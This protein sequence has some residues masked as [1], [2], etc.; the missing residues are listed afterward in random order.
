MTGSG[1]SAS[2][3]LIQLIN[4]ADQDKAP[5]RRTLDAIIGFK[6]DGFIANG[7]LRPSRRVTG[8]AAN[9]DT[10]IGRDAVIL[11]VGDDSDPYTHEPIVDVEAFF[12]AA[13]LQ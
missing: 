3:K 9:T 7:A 1:S 4:L 10:R 2:T 13:L 5:S 11:L 12:V 8:A 6:A